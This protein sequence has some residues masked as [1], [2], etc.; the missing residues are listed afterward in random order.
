MS[1]LFEYA[2][3]YHPKPKKVDG[4]E[5][6]E[7]SQ[8]LVP[9]TSVLADSDKEVAIVASRQIP[10]EYLDKLAQVEILIRPFA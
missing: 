3:V 2:V 7:K 10:E 4:V 9:M 1:K 8:L 6:R 5:H